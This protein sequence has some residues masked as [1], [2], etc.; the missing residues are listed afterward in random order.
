MEPVV[1]ST[2][3]LSFDVE[4]DGSVPVKSSLRQFGLVGLLENGTE[5]TSMQWNVSEEEDRAVS[6]R[7]MKEFWSKHPEQWEAVQKDTV[8]PTEF[9][10]QLSDKLLELEKSHWLVWVASPS[11]YDWM[12]LK[13]YYEL[14]K[15]STSHKL[16]YSAK[17]ISSMFWFYAKQHK[18]TGEQQ[19][20]LWK[21]LM[22]SDDLKH[23]AVSDARD[24]GRLFINLLKLVSGS[25]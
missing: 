5:V 13:S 1:K 21:E 18:L 9:V 19:S 8:T 17:C 11:S 3:Y 23:D 20:K 22:E 14:H 24:Q 15:D 4:C 12:W 25:T 2:L 6:P 7:C 16:A 10:S